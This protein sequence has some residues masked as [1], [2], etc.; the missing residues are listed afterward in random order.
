MK[1][2]VGQFLL[3]LNS[4]AYGEH[5]KFDRPVIYRIVEVLPY[6]IKVVRTINDEDTM[7]IIKSGLKD[8]YKLLSPVE[9][10]FYSEY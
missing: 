3:S 10:E 7:D 4:F 1:Y 8:R 5:G 9:L 6:R 2:Q